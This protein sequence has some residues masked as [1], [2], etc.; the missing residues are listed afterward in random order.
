MAERVSGGGFE[1][2]EHTADVGLRVW[3]S[4]LTEL[5]E[6]A[7]AGLMDLMLD[8][9]TVD[10]ARTMS[11]SA[12]AHEPEELLVAWLEE[13]LFAFEADAFAPATARVVSLGNGE[14]RGELSGEDFNPRRNEV[15]QVIKAV[16]YHDLTIKKVMG[17]YEVRIVFDV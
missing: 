12:L 14:V 16:T 15:R 9:D 17:T 4:S 8:T 6:Q 11:I 3:G 13:I 2:F 7:A 10:A 1:S 5:F